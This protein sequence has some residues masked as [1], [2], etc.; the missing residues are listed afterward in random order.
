MRGNGIFV[1]TD[2]TDRPIEIYGGTTTLL[3]GNP[4]ESYLLL[5]FVPALA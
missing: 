1:H 3:T 2:P 4:Y 5:P